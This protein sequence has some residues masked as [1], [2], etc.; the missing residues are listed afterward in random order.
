MAY[1][2]RLAKIPRKSCSYCE[3]YDLIINQ[4]NRDELRFLQSGVMLPVF[5]GGEILTDGE[6]VVLTGVV[7]VV[8]HIWT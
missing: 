5:L 3:S 2:R 6:V 4:S 1:N 8:V 7:L